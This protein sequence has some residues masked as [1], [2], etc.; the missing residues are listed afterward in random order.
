M[1][2]LEGVAEVPAGV[3]PIADKSMEDLFA[4]LDT[5]VDAQ[6]H[7]DDS[8]ESLARTLR[9]A[10]IRSIDHLNEHKRQKKMLMDRFVEKRLASRPKTKIGT[11]KNVFHLT[12]KTVFAMLKEPPPPKPEGPG[13]LFSHELVTSVTHDAEGTAVEIEEVVAVEV[14]LR[15]NVKA[16]TGPRF[17]LHVKMPVPEPLV[18]GQ[19]GTLFQSLCSTKMGVVTSKHAWGE[20]SP[21]SLFKIWFIISQLVVLTSDDVV[22]DW[23][24]GAGVQL[25]AAFLFIPYFWPSLRLPMVGIEVDKHAYGFLETNIGN[26]ASTY[27]D[28]PLRPRV[29][30]LKADSQNFDFGCGTVVVQYDGPAR[31]WMD[32]EPYIKI[33]YRKLFTQ[34]HVKVV[35]TTKLDPDTFFNLFSGKC[36]EEKVY[37]GKWTHHTIDNLSQGGSHYQAH[38][39][40]RDYQTDIPLDQ[41]EKIIDW[42]GDGA[43]MSL[44]DMFRTAKEA[45]EAAAAAAAC[46]S[47]AAAAAQGDPELQEWCHHE[48]CT[49]RFKF[50][51]IHTGRSA[52]PI[53]RETQEKQAAAV[54]ASS[55]KKSK[56]RPH[57]DSKECAKRIKQ[58]EAEAEKNAAENAADKAA[59]V[60]QKAQN[61]VLMERIEVLEAAVAGQNAALVGSI[62]VREAAA[63]GFGR[64]DEDLHFA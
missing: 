4:C 32:V 1:F 51:H 19:M 8:I 52:A 17:K 38:L 22:L 43:K 48:G 59:L 24:A 45:Q 41:R 2:Q 58:L 57:C 12:L 10:G 47:A 18:L 5:L 20:F 6:S 64:L 25:M 28:G 54:A 33:I 27:P 56:K 13:G 49:M 50:E 14:G 7:L 36:G 37:V 35:L 16:P 55:G 21:M 29:R 11:H 61:V 46:E 63:A 42:K 15:V 34:A 26:F 40:I 31:A 39:Y 62:G 44:D 23:G 60:A 3:V 53:T 9:A 30:V